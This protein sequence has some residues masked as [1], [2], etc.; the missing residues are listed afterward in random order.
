MRKFLLAAIALVLTFSVTPFV[1][2]WDRDVQQPP[3]KAKEPPFDVREISDEQF[4]EMAALI[5]LREIALGNFAA[6]KARRA[7]IQQ[8]AQQL[9]KDHMEAHH[10]LEMIAAKRRLTLPTKLDA[11]HQ[12]KVEE[13]SALPGD[14]FDRAYLKEMVAGHKRATALY[15]HESQDGKVSELKAYAVII[16]PTVRQHYQKATQLWNDYFVSLR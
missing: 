14:E 12:A 3:N 13:L 6:E 2:G 1:P 16:L 15:E 7:D 8:F 11:K 5:N 4:A 10:Q 9:K